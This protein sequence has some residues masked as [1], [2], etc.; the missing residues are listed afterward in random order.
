MPSPRK[1]NKKFWKKNT[2]NTDVG[3]EEAVTSAIRMV[4]LLF[5]LSLLVCRCNFNIT[6]ILFLPCRTLMIQHQGVVAEA[7]SIGKEMKE[8]GEGEEEE[9]LEGQQVGQA[10]NALVGSMTW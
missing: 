5:S 10:T 7:E 6:F 4:F 1:L 9:E 3:Q 8:E 2:N